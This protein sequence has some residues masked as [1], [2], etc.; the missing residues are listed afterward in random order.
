MVSQTT[1][2]S[3][4]SSA[5]S[6]R[7]MKWSLNPYGYRSL[8]ASKA[9]EIW[10]KVAQDMGYAS[11]PGT[12]GLVMLYT[13]PEQHWANRDALSLPIGGVLQISPG[14]ESGHSEKAPG[15]WERSKVGFPAQV[16]MMAVSARAQLE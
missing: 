5:P 13:L 6:V 16:G 1:S 9:G 10:Q 14:M 3:D 2:Q 12:V 8:L 7:H 11:S 15:P 4:G